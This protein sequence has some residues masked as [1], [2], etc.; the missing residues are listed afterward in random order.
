MFFAPPFLFFNICLVNSSII[1]EYKATYSLFVFI[2]TSIVAPVYGL[3]VG[4]AFHFSAIEI[5]SVSGDFLCTLAPTGLTGPFAT[6]DVSVAD[7]DALIFLILGI[8]VKSYPFKFS[9]HHL[10]IIGYIPPLLVYIL[11]PVKRLSTLNWASVPFF[12]SSNQA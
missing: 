2:D 7:N 3:T 11:L 6:F 5:I 8:P 9:K 10:I 12:I 4:F 1:F